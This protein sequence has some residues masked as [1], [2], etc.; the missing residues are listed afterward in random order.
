MKSGPGERGMAS[1][2]GV[3]GSWL[4]MMGWG[5]GLLGWG[6]TVT[7]GG[8]TEPDPGGGG[9][10]GGG[11]EEAVAAA[12]ITHV[13]SAQIHPPEVWTQW[14]GDQMALGWGGT[15]HWPAIHTQARPFQDQWPAIHT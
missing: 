4:T 15:C 7:A 3:G 6:T 13:P 10:G 1:T 9:G 12:G 14:P 2:I 8:V 11:V 5:G